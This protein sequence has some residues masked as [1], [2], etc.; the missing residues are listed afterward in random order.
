MSKDFVPPIRLSRRHLLKTAGIVT[1]ALGASLAVP[2]SAQ[3]NWESGN[4]PVFGSQTSGTTQTAGKK[5]CFLHGTLIRGVNGYRQVQSIA[6]GD[7]LPTQFSGTAVVRKVVSFI[8]RRDEKGR[9]PEETRPVRIRAGA[10]GDNI[11]ARDLVVTPTHAVFLNDVLVPI[12][13]LVN[14]RTISFHDEIGLNSLEYFHLEFDNH[15]V[16]DAE[17]ALCESYRD[18]A[19]EPCAPLALNGPRS[20]LLSHLR[21]AIAPV[22]D[23]RLPLDRIRDGLDIRAGL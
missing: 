5:W 11:P 23:R 21:S 9:W 12:V 17:G 3:Q 6:V 1:G 7:V 18:E 2:A 8:V 19:M 14:G 10:L 4:T 15:D 20:Q 13:S 16:I 22:V